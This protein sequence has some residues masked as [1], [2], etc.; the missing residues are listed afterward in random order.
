MEYTK[1]E[2]A[3]L[4]KLDL[5]KELIEDGIEDKKNNNWF[6]NKNFVQY[7]ENEFFYL[8]KKQFKNNN[9]EYVF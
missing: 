5:N 8:L 7:K 6:F 2:W 3:Y 1:F 9:I 4:I